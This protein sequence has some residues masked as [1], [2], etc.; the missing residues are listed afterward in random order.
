MPH[1]RKKGATYYAEW[2]DPDRHPKRKWVPLRT[3]DKQAAQHRM[4]EY[5][6][7][8]AR[9]EYDPWE[10]SAP[11]EGVLVS[12]AIDA[13]IKARKSRRKETLATDRATLNAFEKSLRP[14][15]LLQ[16]VEP[17][18]V[19]AFLDKPK[20]SGGQRSDAT[21]QIYHARIKTFFTWCTDRKLRK[22]K[23]PAEAV[24]RIKVGKKMPL[25]LTREEVASLIEK[26]E[27]E[28]E[29]L[30]ARPTEDEVRWLADVVRVTVGTGLRASE[31][32][33]LRWSAIDLKGRRLT[34]EVTK[35]F[36]T[37]SGHE[38]VVPLA[39]EALETLGR[40]KTERKPK[41]NDYVFGSRATRKGVRP[42]LDRQYLN[43]R[44]KHYAKEAGLSERHTFHSLRRTYA[45][46][47]VQGG[48]DLYRVQ[49]LL[50]HGDIKTTMKYAFLA[51]DSAKADV[52]RVFG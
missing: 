50:G 32:C 20:K 52:E 35:D 19:R 18:H 49:K 39:G 33:N 11:Q 2:Y 44:F 31:L 47:L 38:R 36:K 45:S 8:Y 27:E 23:N 46:W 12:E 16:H 6:R 51:P 22:G 13:Y 7:E 10:D 3:G 24:E 5:D 43:K 48:T 28:A 29:A 41:A 15:T 26:I 37:K 17:R 30:G 42:K 21:K 40:L 1:L 25:W 4:I 9:G 34:V 14:G